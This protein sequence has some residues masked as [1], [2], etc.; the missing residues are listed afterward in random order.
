[1]NVFAYENIYNNINILGEGDL[2]YGIYAYFQ[3]TTRCF[4]FPLSIILFEF[5]HP[6]Q[7]FIHVNVNDRDGK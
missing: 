2:S 6:Y 5:S 1:M 4:F 3:N 7:R